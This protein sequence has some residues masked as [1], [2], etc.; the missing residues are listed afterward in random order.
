[1]EELLRVEHLKVQF[2]VSESFSGKLFSLRKKYVK[3][4]DDVSFTIHRGEVVALVGESGCGKSTIGKFL[5]SLVEQTSGAV[6]YRGEDMR[7]KG[8][9][10]SLRRN[11][12]YIFQDPFSSLNPRMTVHTILSRPMQIFHLSKTDKE[13][14]EKIQK[15]LREVGLTP[16]N[17]LRF[18]HEFSG[19]QKQRISIARALSVEPELIIADEPT[20]ALDISIQAQILKLLI[21]L[22][23]TL[24]LT[25]LF[26]S[27]DLGV[28]EYI[29]DRILVMYLGT[30]V[31]TGPTGEVIKNPLHPYTKALLSAVPHNPLQ[32]KNVEFRLTGDIPSTVNIP[33]GC[34]LHPR[35]PLA[36]EACKT[37]DVKLEDV[38]PGRQA[39]CIMVPKIR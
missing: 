34:R 29:S 35:C 23:E 7:Q 5:V 38:A 25:M 9:M 19:G 24:G 30:I 6:Y 22:K 4:V 37:C 8:K 26:I 3:A 13:R 28:V 12:Q 27:H 36:T 31:E 15:L 20:A 10:Q 11:V 1:M 14:E 18:P 16:E 21:Q 39:A 32:E 17:A 33:G 2:P